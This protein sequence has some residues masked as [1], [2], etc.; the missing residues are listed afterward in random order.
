MQQSPKSKDTLLN[1]FSKPQIYD[2]S[3][4]KP[5]QYENRQLLAGL[6]LFNDTNITVS[7]QR[8]KSA[9]NRTFL[10]NDRIGRKHQILEYGQSSNQG[11]K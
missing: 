9:A 3:L 4:L 2:Q 6:N 5:N 7:N 1:Q 10:P 8:T 11:T